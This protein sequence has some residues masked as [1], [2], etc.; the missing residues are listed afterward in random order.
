[1]TPI[2]GGG[3]IA[4]PAS[5]GGG[6]GGTPDDGSVTDAKVAVGAEI[7]VA[8]LADGVAGDVVTTDADGVTVIWAAPV[9]TAAA[10]ALKAP[11]ASPALTG[12]PTAPTP[13]AADN[14]TSIAT[15]AYVQTEISGVYAPL[16]SPALT[17]NPTAPTQA[18]DNSST[19][20]ATTAYVIGQA[21]AVADGTPAANGTAARGTSTHWARADHVHPTDTTL[22]PLASPTFTGN[23]VAPTPAAN[24]NDTSIATTAYVQ[25]EIAN[26]MDGNARVGVR[27]N[28]AGS[29]FIRRR[30][31]LIEGSN[32][33]L[34]VADDSGSE[35]VD[36]TIAASGGGASATDI[37]FRA[38]AMS[39]ADVTVS[40]PGTAVF[41]GITL[42]SGVDVLFLKGQSTPAQNGLYLF[43]GSGSALTRITS[44]DSSAEV[45]G[46]H[47][48][49]VERG[50]LNGATLWRNTNSN[51]ITLDTT[52]LTYICISGVGNNGPAITGLSGA[53]I[54]TN[55][56]LIT[57]GGGLI[58]TFGH[59]VQFDYGWRTTPAVNTA[60]FTIATTNDAWVFC[61][62]TAAVGAF[63]GNL[64]ASPVV[65]QRV[66][67]IDV[68]AAGAGNCLTANFTIGRNGK[69]I[70]G[71]ASNIVMNT[72]RQRIELIYA[73]TAQGWVVIN[74]ETV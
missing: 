31:N 7:A 44:M 15:T 12:N 32:V 25:T 8:K 68:G 53:T 35:E 39:T 38:K 50:T 58:D 2:S 62:N 16:A 61:V 9:V 40:N 18:V 17:G 63:T 37:G 73:S 55:G 3:G 51:V 19:R 4:P 11:L 49:I 20:L 23:P 42:T 56:G 5:G 30:I 26:D 54:T 74:N 71:V 33:T 36:V 52:S 65:G 34:T 21:S 69:N 29:T 64:P 24:D 72:N 47:L 45:L 66:M 10:L 60:T 43:N 48:V 14:D 6:G 27:K 22:A 1:M 70:N 59:E 46:G 41:D 57:G 28:S 13:A 67:F